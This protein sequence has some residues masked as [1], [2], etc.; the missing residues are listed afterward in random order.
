MKSIRYIVA[1]SSITVLC[2]CATTTPINETSST[3]GQATAHNK[4]LHAVPPTADQKQNTYIPADRARQDL[5]RKRYKN[6]EVEEPVSVGT[7]R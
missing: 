4:A 1:L 5:A 7:T 6:D 3:F 2:A